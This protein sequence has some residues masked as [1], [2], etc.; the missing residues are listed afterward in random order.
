MFRM[1]TIAFLLTLTAGLA[2]AQD[3]NMAIGVREAL[4][5]RGVRIPEDV[6]LVGFDNIDVPEATRRGV[7]VSNTPDVLTEATAE[8]AMAL[9][10]GA[11]AI[12]REPLSLRMVAVPAVAVLLL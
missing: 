4:L 12:G 11:L 3:D 8:L 1:L 5:A 2:V 6:G 9:V 7:P 10:L